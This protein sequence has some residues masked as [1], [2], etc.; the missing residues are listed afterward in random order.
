M[1][2]LNVN[3]GIHGIDDT[4]KKVPTQ[5]KDMKVI[6]QHVVKLKMQ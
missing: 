3:Q 1:I 6:I 5:D 4:L 2:H